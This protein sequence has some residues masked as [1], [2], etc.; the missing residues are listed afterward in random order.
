M[1]LRSNGEDMP[2]HPPRVIAVA[3]LVSV[4]TAPALM[5]GPPPA[6]AQAPVQARASNAPVPDHSVSGVVKSVDRTR[7]VITRPGKIPVEMTFSVNASTLKE[8]VIAV[9]VKVQVRYRGDVHAA[10]ATAVLAAPAH[11]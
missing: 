8:G 9:G 3:A 10:V 4:L 11:R 6:P 5:A 1:W 7:L 2:L